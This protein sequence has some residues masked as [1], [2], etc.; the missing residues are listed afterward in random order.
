MKNKILVYDCTLYGKILGKFVEGELGVET[1]QIVDYSRLQDM[2]DR[3]ICE[4]I[5]RKI[6]PYVDS[7]MAI[8]ITCPLAV[9]VV[10]GELEK[11]FPK[12]RFVYLGKDIIDELKG[13]DKV[14]VLTLPRVR[15]TERYQMRKAAC[16]EAEIEELSCTE[17]IGLMN[18]GWW[19]EE[20]IAKS[21]RHKLG[22]KLVIYHSAI[23]LREK[24]VGEIVD[25]RGELIDVKKKVISPVRQA[26]R[27]W[28]ADRKK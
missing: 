7:V 19:G 20:K 27:E 10:A 6:E 9:T 28:T 17:W 8:L 3:E 15:R 23:L 25:W 11:I 24:E 12:Q 26:V 22:I 14:A 16:Q 21:F 18:K 5:V 4:H 13:S 2:S 1:K